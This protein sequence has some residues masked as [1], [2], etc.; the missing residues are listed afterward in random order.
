[1]VKGN[2]RVRKRAGASKWAIRLGGLLEGTLDTSAFEY[3]G[4][5]EP[6]LGSV[7]CETE[8]ASYGTVI[9]LAQE[10]WDVLLRTEEGAQTLHED[11]HKDRKAKEK[12]REKKQRRKERKAHEA[13]KPTGKAKSRSYS[14]SDE[15][16]SSSGSSGS[17]SDARTCTRPA[18]QGGGG[19]QNYQRVFETTQHAPGAPSFIC[20]K[21]EPHFRSRNTG[22]LVNCAR[23]PK[24]PCRVCGHCHWYWQGAAYACRG[25][26]A[27]KQ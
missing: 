19:D 26:Y 22:D 13:G 25:Q 5:P 12:R 6:D 3:M 23:P 1:M 2:T 21:G 20:V 7:Q 8:V 9:G 24:T 17:S 4:G 18:A 10:V 15:S 11:M 16:S 14:S 27:K